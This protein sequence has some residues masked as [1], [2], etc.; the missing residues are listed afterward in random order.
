MQ[1]LMLAAGMGKRLGNYT[2]NATKCMVP[3]NG[4]TLIEY[5]IESLIYAGIKKFTMVVGYKKDVLKNFLKG[6]Y[7]QIQIDFI[8]NDVYDS[9]NNIYSLYLARD[10][11]SS[12]DTIL[13]ESDLIFDKE[14]I[15]EIVS[16][17]EKNLAVV[18]HFENWMDG[19]VTVLNEEKAIKR[20]VSKSDFDWNK[21]DSYYKTVNI[22][23]FSK[24][25]SKNIYMPFLGAYQTAYSKNEYYETVLKVISYLDGD[26]LKAHLVDGSRWYEIDD[27]ADLKIASTRFSSGKEHLESMYK[28]FGGYWRYPSML[29][30]CYLVNPYFPPKSLVNEMKQ[31]SD[32]LLES[33]PSGDKQQSLLA[34]KIFGVLPEHIA[35]GNG[36]AELIA[37]ISELSSGK[38]VVPFPTFNEYPNRFGNEN[39]V[40][41]SANE[42]F[43]YSV[44]DIVRSAEENS[45]SYVLLINPDNPSGHF[46][47][48]QEVIVLAEQLS[49][50]NVKLILDESFVDFAEPEIRFTFIDEELISKHKNVIVIKSISKSYGVPGIRLGVLVSGDESLIEKIQKNTSIWNIN[51]FAEFFLQIFDKYKKFYGSACDKIAEERGRFSSELSKIPGVKVYESQA[52]YLLCKLSGEAE[53]IGSLGLAEKLLDG[54]NILIKDLSSKKGFEKG[55][56]IRLAVR[57][58][59]DN[60][61]L[62]F[63]LKE[64]FS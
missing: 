13:L 4:K 12:D 26:I 22:Y 17:P 3:V 37:S 27:P 41:L 42:D 1:A 24:E 64:I 7:P 32:I 21:I 43:S 52:N 61:R 34:G 35:V 33:Y 51:S 39:T 9:T 19:T 8:D 30:F 58:C 15:R 55:Q 36:A 38:V 50:K 31:M 28:T 56:F 25:F 54:Y 62:I 63:A 18:S 59:Q 5:A 20:I 53:K 49:S 45:A 60:D 6:K 29:D 11:L 23:K 44:E 46:F 2:K 14:I 48:K 47:T 57:N 10:V 16:S 40:W